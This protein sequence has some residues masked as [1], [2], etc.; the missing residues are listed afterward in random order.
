M[1]MCLR[2]AVAATILVSTGCSSST[3]SGGAATP[4]ASKVASTGASSSGPSAPDFTLPT[5]DGKNLSLSDYLGKSVVLIDFW[6][7]TCDPCLVEIPH[8][9]ELYEK[10]KD[11]GFVVLAISADGPET[12]AQVTSVIHDKKMSF[13][14]LLDEET[15]VIARY[16]PRRDMPFTVLIDK[17]GA[18][19]R[20]QSGYTPGDELKLAAEVEKLLK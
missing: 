3:S 6:A 4:D 15:T 11:K 9:V 10:H 12:R 1:T 16:N 17:S 2:A 14:V 7:T 5:P 8:L 20:K 18:I 19:V 13:P